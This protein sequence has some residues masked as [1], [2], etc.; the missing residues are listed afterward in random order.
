MIEA[1]YAELITK[2]EAALGVSVLKAYP[3][4]ARPNQAPPIAALEISTIT[5]T[6]NRIGQHSARHVLGLRFYVFGEHEPGLGALLD[7]MLTLEAETGRLEIAGR[8]VDFLF[9]DGQ[10]Y[11]GQTGAQQ[12]NHGFFWSVNAIW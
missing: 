5:G 8:P 1:I 7:K 2:A 12:E 9:S 3:T 4:W 6:D 10:R 11:E